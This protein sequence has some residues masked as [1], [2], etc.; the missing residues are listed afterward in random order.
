[1]LIL[2]YQQWN[3]NKRIK[4]EESNL[5][6]LISL[7]LNIKLLSKYAG[8][9]ILISS[10]RKITRIGIWNGLM[11]LSVSRCWVNCNR[12]RKLIIFLAWAHFQGKITWPR[13]WLKCKLPFLSST[14]SAPGP[15]SSQVTF[16]PS[17]LTTAMLVEEEKG[18]L[19]LWNL[20]QVVKAEEFS[21]HSPSHVFT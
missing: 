18:R 20:R 21:C 19:L 8:I 13:I 3:K 14:V 2:I 7:I 16:I 5:L 11:E 10:W 15:S 1:M 6:L 9:L 12:I 4:K 17:R